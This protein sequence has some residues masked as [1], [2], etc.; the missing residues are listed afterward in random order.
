MKAFCQDVYIF[1]LKLLL[2]QYQQDENLPMLIKRET[3]AAF[4][5]STQET[6]AG[7]SRVQGQSELHS[8]FQAAW[9]I[10]KLSQKRKN[11][12]RRRGK[13]GREEEEKEK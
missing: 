1:F 3:D 12:K 9:V 13:G 11:K 5:P 10:V 8:E 4:N 6:E 7:G 2:S